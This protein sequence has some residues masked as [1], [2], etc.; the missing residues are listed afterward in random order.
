MDENINFYTKEEK[1]KKIKK[2]LNKLKRKFK[3]IPND[4]KEFY[5][6]LMQRAAFMRVT[7]EEL[8]LHMNYH[9]AVEWFEQGSQKL[10]RESPASKVYN[11]MIKNYQ[12]TLKQLEMLLPEEEKKK[13]VNDYDGFGSFVQ[14]KKQGIP[15]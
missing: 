8:E 13:V 9:G 14:A 6:G 1:E 2:E 4:K 15:R 11:Q 10:W 3:D 12:A 7:L 5:L